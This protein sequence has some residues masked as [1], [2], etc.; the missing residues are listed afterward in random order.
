MGQ[1]LCFVYTST[2]G[3]RVYRAKSRVHNRF[4]N[5]VTKGIRA[6]TETAD[7]TQEKRNEGERQWPAKK[8]A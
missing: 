6:S 4:E 2:L 7:Q 1:L 8:K 5:R 3:A